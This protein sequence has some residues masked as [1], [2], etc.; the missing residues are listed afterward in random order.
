M[1]RKT[2]ISI[3]KRDKLQDYCKRNS[4]RYLAFE[5]MSEGLTDILVTECFLNTAAEYALQWVRFNYMNQQRYAVMIHY[6]RCGQLPKNYPLSQQHKAI[7]AIYNKAKRSKKRT[8][9]SGHILEIEKRLQ[10][11]LR[12]EPDINNHHDFILFTIQE[13]PRALDF[14]L[15]AKAAI[16][17]SNKILTDYTRPLDM[18]S[19]E[20]A[21]IQD[22][23]EMHAKSFISIKNE[24]ELKRDYADILNSK[25]QKGLN[26]KLADTLFVTDCLYLGLER[27]YAKSEISRYWKSTGRFPMKTKKDSIEAARNTSDS[28]YSNCKALAQK[29]C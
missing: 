4:N 14:L 10:S 8:A 12:A 9:F 18:V 7:I 21:N 20:V 25:G 29:Y 23:Y 11:I 16:P 28:Y 6:S 1:S 3:E 2:T 26:G 5:R 27:G 19:R 17:V 13:D 15:E 22:N 24:V